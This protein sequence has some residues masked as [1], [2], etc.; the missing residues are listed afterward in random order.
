MR[1]LLRSL[2][3]LLLAALAMPA[4]AERVLIVATPNVPAG[5]FRALAEIGQR[6]G[7]T[8]EH[9]Y[10]QR[11]PAQADGSLWA[12]YDAVFI[13]SYLQD[14]V[15]AKLVRALPALRVPNAWLYDQKPA[16]SGMPDALG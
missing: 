1:R 2:L 3:T 11:I 13:D 6:H 9:R 10:L 7:I 16:W 4:L 15:R 8:L 14:E 5:K 12:G